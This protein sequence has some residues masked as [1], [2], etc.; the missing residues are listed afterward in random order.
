ML[1]TQRTDELT[2]SEESFRTLFHKG[3]LPVIMLPLGESFLPGLISD[4]NPA[5]CALLRYTLEEMLTLAPRDL[6]PSEE[7]VRFPLLINELLALGYVQCEMTCITKADKSIPVQMSMT[8][9]IFRGQL[10]A[11]T[12]LEE[13]AEGSVAGWTG[14]DVQRENR[15]LAQLREAFIAK[16]G[17]DV[18]APKNGVLSLMGGCTDDAT[19]N[20]MAVLQRQPLF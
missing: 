15:L 4:A 17:P 5:V 10:V 6:V 3:A 16:K 18:L 19:G 1:V 20:V 2:A 12:T 11:M 7:I 13:I 9:L 14:E 8:R